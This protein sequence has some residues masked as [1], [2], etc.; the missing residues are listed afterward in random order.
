MKYI[1][2]DIDGIVNNYPIS[3]YN[4]AFDEL[5]LI[6]KSK[7]ELIEKLSLNKIE[8]ADFKYNYRNL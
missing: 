7:N 4:Y 8:Y 2:L 3:M 1:S 5:G 6:V